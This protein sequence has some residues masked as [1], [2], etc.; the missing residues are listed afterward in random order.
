MTS[1]AIKAFHP[2]STDVIEQPLAL[3]ENNPECTIRLRTPAGA[4]GLHLLFLES[5]EPKL[6]MEMLTHE[7]EE[8]DIQVMLDKQGNLHAWGTNE[9]SFLLTL[10]GRYYPDKLIPP[11]KPEQSLDIAIIIDATMRVFIDETITENNKEK[12]RYVAKLLIEKDKQ[13]EKPAWQTYTETLNAFIEAI[14]KD[15]K[16]YKIAIL[17]FGDQKPPN[18]SAPEL[19]PDY[20]LWP[21]KTK[22]FLQPLTSKQII[23][24]LQ[25][26]EATSGG[27][28]VDALADAL[29]ASVQLNW[30]K[31]ARKLVIVVGDSPGHSILYP[32]PRGGDLCARKADVDTAAMHL[33]HLGIEIVTI[34][35]AP[36]EEAND[37]FKTLPGSRFKLLPHTQEQYQRLASLPELAFQ[38]SEFDPAQA[39]EIFC[40]RT[41]SIGRGMVFGEFLDE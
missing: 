41:V 2:N 40:N 27:D 35:N 15:I 12:R 8:V 4:S 6:R 30:R 21:E 29:V 31:N 14:V 37:Y 13:K 24:M 18:I 28:F 3:D 16:D 33:H 11:P 26:I 20:H 19:L 1:F 5:G 7:N 36:S 38:I 32:V 9:D 39:A 22:R 34:Y 10:S 23:R 25:S 17:A